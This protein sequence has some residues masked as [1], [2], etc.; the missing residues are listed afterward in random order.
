MRF[1]FRN[2]FYYWGGY[3]RPFVLSE[4]RTREE[5]AELGF[6]TIGTWPC[7]K[8]YSCDD[9][10]WDH[11]GLVYRVGPDAALDVHKRIKWI[12]EVPPNRRPDEIPIDVP[13]GEPATVIAPEPPAGLTAAQAG[14][15][16]LVLGAVAWWLAS[17]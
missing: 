10:E 14:S 4:K 12:R 2:G 16:A 7:E 11:V 15:V 3:D 13:K 9:A 6:V 8:L 17:R 5:L 1:L